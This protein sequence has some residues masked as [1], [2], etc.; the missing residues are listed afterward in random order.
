MTGKWSFTGAILDDALVVSGRCDQM[1]KQLR[2]LRILLSGSH[3]EHGPE[4][5]ILKTDENANLSQICNLI[6]VRSTQLLYGEGT[7]STQRKR[8]R[9]KL[10]QHGSFEAGGNNREVILWVT[11]GV[12]ARVLLR[13]DYTDV[14]Q[15]CLFPNNSSRHLE[16]EIQKFTSGY[17]CIFDC[18]SFSQVN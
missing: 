4:F 16:G 9:A 1:G 5:R 6:H 3:Q 13:D 10:F 12:A 18:R 14:H 8:I 11:A 2:G 17:S 7:K 15:M